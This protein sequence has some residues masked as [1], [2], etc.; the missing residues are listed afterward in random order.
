MKKAANFNFISILIIS[1]ILFIL[2][3]T[4]QFHILPM[5]SGLS[6]LRET[7]SG[8]Q[9]QDEIGDVEGYAFLLSGAA[10]IF[11]AFTTG[12]IIAICVI[13]EFLAVLLFI[14]NLIARIVYSSDGGC[15]LAYRIIMGIEY[16]GITA[17][18]LLLIWLFGKNWLI[19]IPCGGYCLAVT[20]IG[21]INTYTARIKS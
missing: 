15:L 21:C 10:Y 4:V 6:D 20:V 12:I 16:A 2:A 17:F 19:C 3:L 13:V 11:G 18:S 14:P 9:H 1:V 8:I 5:Q 7:M